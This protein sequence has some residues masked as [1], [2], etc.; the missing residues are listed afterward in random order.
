MTK[1][2]KSIEVFREFVEAFRCPH[3]KSPLQ[4]VDLKSLKCTKNHT[5][6]F[7]KQGYVNLTTH[8]SKS[9]Y[10]KKLFEARQK[11]IM[12]SNLYALLH[13]KISKVINDQFDN[14]PRFPL[15][16][17]DA[18]CGEG[19][20]LHK[21]LDECRNTTITGVGL[22]ISKAGIVIA[23]KNYKESIWVVGDLAKSPLEDQSLNVIFNILSPSNYKEFKRILVPNGLVIKV[24]PRPNYLKELRE[25]LFEDIKK[26][27]YKSNDTTELFKKH[28]KLKGVFNLCY[29]KKLNQ[30]ELINLV[31][32]SPL[33]WNTERTDI[34]SFINRVSAEITV[35]L[36][37]LVG[38]NVR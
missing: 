8:S 2:I 16:I 5:F 30:E 12:E 13:K 21:I 19:S 34:N 4:V 32:M 25:V 20:H 18:G 36:D 27:V 28:F 26:V 3:C 15:L 9:H 31:Q 10:D 17:L 7:A 14:H 24:V 35:D 11:I 38:L 22:D 1:K 6:D 37:I 29:K 23:A 33:S